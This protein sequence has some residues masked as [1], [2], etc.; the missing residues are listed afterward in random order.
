M[1]YNKS[2]KSTAG[3]TLS[4]SPSPFLSIFHLQKHKKKA[5][6]EE[7]GPPPPQLIPRPKSR[8][9]SQQSIVKHASLDHDPASTTNDTQEDVKPVSSRSRLIGPVTFETIPEEDETVL[10]DSLKVINEDEQR[11]RKEVEYVRGDT[12]AIHVQMARDL[13]K[14]GTHGKFE[15][16]NI[17]TT[18]DDGNKEEITDAT[19]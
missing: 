19:T 7:I 2:Q 16:Q 3:Q 9:T 18:E 6:S 1:V 5:N 17:T 15:D 13:G 4:L 11:G 14:E 12:T 8:P 10:E